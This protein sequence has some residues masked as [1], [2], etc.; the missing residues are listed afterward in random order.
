MPINRFTDKLD[1]WLV[2]HNNRLSES[3]PINF[4]DTQFQQNVYQSSKIL[5]NFKSDTEC[6]PTKSFRDLAR[7]WWICFPTL[8]RNIMH[9]LVMK[10]I[11]SVDM[12]IS[13]RLSLINICKCRLDNTYTLFFLYTYNIHFGLCGWIAWILCRHSMCSMHRLN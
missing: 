12:Q 13:I 10:Y 9:E 11:H 6:L 2:S 1:L 3:Q 7:L 4:C 5:K 8:D